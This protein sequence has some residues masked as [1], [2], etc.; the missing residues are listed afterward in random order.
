MGTTGPGLGEISYNKFPGKFGGMTSSSLNPTTMMKGCCRTLWTEEDVYPTVELPMCMY[1]RFKTRHLPLHSNHVFVRS[2]LNKNK[3]ALLVHCIHQHS[4]ELHEQEMKEKE[5]I[6][7]R[8][9]DEECTTSKPVILAMPTYERVDMVTY[10]KKRTLK[11][12][13]IQP[14]GASMPKEIEY[15]VWD[16]HKLIIVLPHVNN[17]DMDDTY[18]NPAFEAMQIQNKDI[19][20]DIR[21][22]L[23]YL[24]QDVDPHKKHEEDLSPLFII[25]HF[26][27]YNDVDCMIRGS[28]TNN[29]NENKKT[30]S[31][32][33]KRTFQSV[34]INRVYDPH[35]DEKEETKE[36]H[37]DSIRLAVRIQTTTSSVPNSFTSSTSNRTTCALL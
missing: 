34:E 3:L 25:R 36:Y 8:D 37:H 27:D 10:Y 32:F 22:M 14:L 19:N 5:S 31:P 4:I 24:L 29:Y 16:E 17:Y 15:D 21:D 23:K 2:V 33:Y 13:K 6:L 26:M 18:P 9:N 35:H 30:H 1:F 12:R 7:I 11:Q 28:D 20:K